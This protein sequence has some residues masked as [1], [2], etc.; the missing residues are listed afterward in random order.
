MLKS[1][2]VV[3]NLNCVFVHV[4]LKD[5]ALMLREARTRCDLKLPFFSI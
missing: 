2:T 5:S 1:L 3:Y 4:I